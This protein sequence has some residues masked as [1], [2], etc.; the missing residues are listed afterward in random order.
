MIDKTNNLK[1]K[2]DEIN[3]SRIENKAIITGNSRRILEDKYTLSSN[4]VIYDKSLNSVYSNEKSMLIDGN[5][6][7]IKF[8]KFNLDLDKKKAK[9]FNLDLTDI[10]KNN[11][12]L[13]EAFIDLENNEVVGKD[14]KL[15]F[16]KSILGNIENDHEFMEIQL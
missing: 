16:D 5:G 6:N 9:V 4:K 14:L 12:I 8:S 13:N 1:I 11:F 3:F 2:S 10:D 15:F 7:E